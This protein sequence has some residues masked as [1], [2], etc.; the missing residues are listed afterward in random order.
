MIIE[1]D[2]MRRELDDN[3]TL[4]SHVECEHC[5]KFVCSRNPDGT[6]DCFGCNRE[7]GE[8]I[9]DP[10]GVRVGCL[11]DDCRE[12]YTLA[13]VVKEIEDALSVRLPL[14]MDPWKVD[15]ARNLADRL[16]GEFNITIKE[17]KRK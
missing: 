1:Q 7:M 8:D 9:F 16:R 17:G 14:G 2:G 12:A 3:T 4:D 5:G 6:S 11:H 10:D 13:L 15:R